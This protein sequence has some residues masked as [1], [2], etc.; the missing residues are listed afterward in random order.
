MAFNITTN[1]SMPGIGFYVYA[2]PQNPT[3]IENDGTA[4]LIFYADGTYYTLL[5][6]VADAISITGATIDSW[7]T[8]TPFKIGTLVI[9]NPTDDVTITLTP[10]QAITPLQYNKPFQIT[11]KAPIDTRIILT[12]KQM[13]ETVTGKQPDIYF[14]ICKD[15]GKLYIWNN[16]FTKSPETGFFKAYDEILNVDSMTEE[17]ILEICN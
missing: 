9:S 16:T 8:V 7:T 1:I 6:K 4:T 2:D 14:C 11:A 12:K 15:D 17:E 10:K 3:S 13:L 5:K